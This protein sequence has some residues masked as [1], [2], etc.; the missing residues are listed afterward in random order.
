MKN[1]QT[2]NALTFL[3]HIILVIGGMN[4]TNELKIHLL[5]L[6]QLQYFTYLEFGSENPEL[7]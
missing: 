4:V 2:I 1:P 5:V 7:T 6:I 3:T